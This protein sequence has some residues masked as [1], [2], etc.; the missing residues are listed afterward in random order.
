MKM[1]TDNTP[2]KQIIRQKLASHNFNSGCIEEVM[3]VIDKHYPDVSEVEG[4]VFE[5]VQTV[6][7]V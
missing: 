7:T 2:V 5:S 4:V 6:P 3:R 1:I